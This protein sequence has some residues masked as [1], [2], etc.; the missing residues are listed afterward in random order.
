M[1][2]YV[3]PHLRK[4]MTVAAPAETRKRGV[5]WPSN[6]HGDPTANVRSKKAPTTFR[7][8]SQ[9]RSQKYSAISKRLSSR[10]LRVKPVKSVLKKGKTMK[11]KRP[12][13]I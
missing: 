2:A 11:V 1:P 9:T 10:K 7:E 4:K 8:G 6:A 5:H 3:P 12:A 13:T